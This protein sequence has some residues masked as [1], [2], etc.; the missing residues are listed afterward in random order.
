MNK[1]Y[2][3]LFCAMVLACLAQAQPVKPTI[4]SPTN[5]AV[6]VA[7]QPDFSINLSTGLAD[8]FLVELDSL[9]TFTSLGKRVSNPITA[10]VQIVPSCPRSN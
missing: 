4:Y 9:A 10:L 2:V 7:L 6:N 8:S 3:Y 5:N 1:G